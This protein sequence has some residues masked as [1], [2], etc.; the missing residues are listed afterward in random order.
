ML[1]RGLSNTW[2]EVKMQKILVIDHGKNQVTMIW[3][4]LASQLQVLSC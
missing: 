1:G 3:K 2:E 4:L